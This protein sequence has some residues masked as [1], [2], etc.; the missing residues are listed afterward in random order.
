MLYAVFGFS[1]K[2]NRSSRLSPHWPLLLALAVPSQPVVVPR[3]RRL[4]VS[5]CCF[6]TYTRGFLD[7]PQWPSEFAQG[8][9]LVFVLSSFKT[10]VMP[11]EPIKAPVGL[12]L[13]GF[14]V[15]RF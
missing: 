13:P 15:G 5:A 9:H 11:K 6:S 2:P 10:L 12:N 4:Q 7:A 8:Y 14:L 3:S 1:G